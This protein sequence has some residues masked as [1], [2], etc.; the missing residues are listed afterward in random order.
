MHFIKKRRKKPLNK[1]FLPLK[2]NIQ[3]RNK[4]LNLKKKK[5]QSLQGWL[6]KFK[7]KKFYDPVSYLLFNFKDFFSRKFKNNLLNKQRLSLFYG[8]LRKSYLKKI[9]KSTLNEFKDLKKHPTILFIQKI[10][11]RLDTA[12][13]R[14]HFSYSF[15]NA[16]QLISHRKIFVNN[17]IVQHNSYSLKK[18]DLITLDKSTFKFVTLNVL[19]SKIWPTPPKHL[20]VNYRTLQI[21]IIEDIHYSSHLTYYHFWIDLSSFLKFYER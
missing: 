18:G 5:W 9:V 15:E 20:Y 3:N 7:K 10:E 11:T 2:K 16:R 13:Y 1:K 6:F 8:K 4:L 12:L 19:N 17:K 14:A 21:L